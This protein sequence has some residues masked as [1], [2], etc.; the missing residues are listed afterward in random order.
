MAAVTG[1]TYMLH[2]DRPFGHAAMGVRRRDAT[3]LAGAKGADS[4]PA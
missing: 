4:C 1:S 2:F 3:D